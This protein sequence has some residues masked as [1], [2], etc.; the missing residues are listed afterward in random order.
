MLRILYSWPSLLGFSMAISLSISHAMQIGTQPISATSL[1]QFDIG[2]TSELT[3][4]SYTAAFDTKSPQAAVIVPELP[5]PAAKN[6]SPSV[7]STPAP[8]AMIHVSINA[9]CHSTQTVSVHHNGLMLSYPIGKTGV[10]DFELPALAEN[11]IVLTE[12]SDNFVAVNRTRIQ[13]LAAFDRTALQWSGDLDLSLLSTETSNLRTVHVGTKGARQAMILTAVRVDNLDTMPN[14]QVVSRDHSACGA[15]VSFQTIA[16]KKAQAAHVS[17]FDI[18]APECS[19]ETVDLVL[20]NLREVTKL[21][22]N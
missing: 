1:E 19:A 7:T 22:L 3:N 17:T 5:S 16:V 4:L 12:F 9:P 20:K 21:A 10:L 14:L 11:A 13:A 8:N 15:L 18:Q 2:G 6:C